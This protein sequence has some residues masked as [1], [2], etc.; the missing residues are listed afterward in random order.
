VGRAALIVLAAGRFM[1][2]L[3]SALMRPLVRMLPAFH[4]GFMAGLVVAACIV[5]I[6]HCEVLL[7]ICS[8]DCYVWVDFHHLT[9]Q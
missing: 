5:F 3:L 2:T 1:R 9:E 8:G 7:W 4:L 6:C